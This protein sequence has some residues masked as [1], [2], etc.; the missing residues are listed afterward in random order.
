MMSRVVPSVG[1]CLLT[2]CLSL[3]LTLSHSLTFPRTDSLTFS[4]TLTLWHSFSLSHVLQ[5]SHS[6]THWHLFSLSHSLTYTLFLTLFDTHSLTLSRSHTLSCRNVSELWKLL[7]C[8]DK[9][10]PDQNTLQYIK[11]TQTYRK[12]FESSKDSREHAWCPTLLMMWVTEGRTK[13]IKALSEKC[14]R[15]GIKQTYGGLQCNNN[16]LHIIVWHLL[17]LWQVGD[18]SQ[19]QVLTGVRGQF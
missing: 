14:T 8:I 11:H 15:G 2:L 3:T 17:K 13:S 12:R 9:I 16:V 1:G 10:E 6:L 19:S 5:H 7:D 4:D 18:G